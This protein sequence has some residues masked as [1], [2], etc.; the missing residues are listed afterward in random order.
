LLPFVSL[1]LIYPS[2]EKIGDFLPN[3]ILVLFFQVVIILLLTSYFSALAAKK[4]LSNSITNYSDLN[5]LINFFIIRKKT[6]E[7]KVETIK[8]L[9]F[10]AKLY[11]IKVD[12]SLLFIYVYQLIPNRTNI[13]EILGDISTESEKK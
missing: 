1:W 4:E 8:K 13:Q 10:S 6:S 5:S 3:V 7:E 9:F 2:K 11:D 12:D